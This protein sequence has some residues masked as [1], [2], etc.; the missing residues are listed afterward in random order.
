MNELPKYMVRDRPELVPHPE[1]C[2]EDKYFEVIK[3]KNVDN[4]DK[5]SA[6]TFEQPGHYQCTGPN[7][8]EMWARTSETRFIGCGSRGK[9]VLQSIIN[10]GELNTQ[11][12]GKKVP[13]FVGTNVG[14]QNHYF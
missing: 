13:K 4:C 3:T 2:A 12:F 1:Q 11:L 9:M 8:K 7:C 5:R 10:Q 14:L 6:F